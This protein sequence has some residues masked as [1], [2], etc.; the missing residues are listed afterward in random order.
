LAGKESSFVKQALLLL[1]QASASPAKFKSRT[2]ARE[3]ASLAQQGQ[4]PTS[5]CVGF[6]GFKQEK[7][8]PSALG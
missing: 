6:Q 5:F 1:A 3:H 2:A 7:R 4:H 8:A